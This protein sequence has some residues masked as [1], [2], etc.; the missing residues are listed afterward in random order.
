VWGEGS[1]YYDT[2]EDLPK[3]SDG[4]AWR[5]SS[6]RNARPLAGEYAFNAVRRGTANNSNGLTVGTLYAVPFYN[7]G[8][9]FAYD[10][11]AMN[12]SVAGAAGAVVRAGH[13]NLDASGRIGNRLLD[14]G[15][16]DWTTTGDK[17]W[18]VTGVMPHGIS[19]L[20]AVTNDA[21]V[22]PRWVGSTPAL[23]SSWWRGTSGLTVNAD[24]SLSYTGYTA[25][26]ALPAVGTT[27][28][29]AKLSGDVLYIGVRAA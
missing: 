13:Y 29:E 28:G 1:F 4:A 10:R 2:V 23:S 11:I 14:A 7:P 27:A 12:N 16:T 25:T 22:R 19:L 18:T 26:S 3:W 5:S 6:F 15:T 21:A 24:H 17:L 9:A 8:P 20:T